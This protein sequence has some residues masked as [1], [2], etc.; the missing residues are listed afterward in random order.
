M[1][2]EI[3]NCFYRVSVKALIL[4]GTRTKFMIVQEHDGRWELPGGGLDFGED[5]LDGVARELKEEMG[6]NVIE[7]KKTPSYFTTMLSEKGLNIA[8][9]IYEVKVGDLNFIP[10]DECVALKFVSPNDIVGMNVLSTVSALAKL[11]DPKNH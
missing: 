5:P 2:H 9:I 6:L 10:S 11:F 4:D 3:P 7:I 8:N 1:N